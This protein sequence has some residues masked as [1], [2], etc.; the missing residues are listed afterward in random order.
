MAQRLGDLLIQEGILNAA[1]L[2][3]AL[4]YQVIF[5]GKLGTDLIEMGFVEEEDVARALSKKFGVPAVDAE[6]LMKTPPAV[7]EAFP[8]ALVEKF[9]VVPCKLDGKRLSLAMSDPS[10][11]KALDEIAF[12][13]G[14]IVKPLVAAEV[15]IVLAL[16]KLYGI[17]RERRYIHAVKKVASRRRDKEKEKE[18]KEKKENREAKA[19]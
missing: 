6:E 12:R 17:E 15:R 13:T 16:E 14:F 7:L 11:L 3:E 2:E 8:R 9:G 18:G 10:D 1:Q 5:G 4:K 19:A